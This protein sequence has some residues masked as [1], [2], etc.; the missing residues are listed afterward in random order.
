M[1]RIHL[2]MLPKSQR[3]PELTRLPT[4]LMSGTPAIDIRSQ[5]SFIKQ[6]QSNKKAKGKANKKEKHVAVRIC[7]FFFSTFFRFIFAFFR[8][9]LAFFWLFFLGGYSKN[10]SEK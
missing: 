4:T 8:I 10:K 6:K 9:F 5:N 2:N 7:R 1:N 3:I